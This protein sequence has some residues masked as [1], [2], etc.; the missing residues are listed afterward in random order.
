M[1]DDS[2]DIVCFKSVLGGIGR[3]DRYDRQQ[4][5]ISEM[6]RV[7]KPD[8]QL[9]FAENLKGSGV[10]R[11]ARERFVSW[12]KDWRYVNLDEVRNLLSGFGDVHLGTYGFFGAFGRNEGQRRLLSKLDSAFM[13]I[14]PTKSRY[15]VFGVG[16]K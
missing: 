4:K 10:H 5:A 11:F 15:I 2:F 3:G 14:I 6:H 12:G 8:G 9:F 7:L 13:K 1:P 16:R